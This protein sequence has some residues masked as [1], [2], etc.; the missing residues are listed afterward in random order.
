MWTSIYVQLDEMHDANL[1]ANRSERMFTKTPLRGS[2]SV[3]RNIETKSTTVVKTVFYSPDPAKVPSH[4]SGAAYRIDTNKALSNKPP[5]TKEGHA[6][7]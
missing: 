3:D 4:L 1:I 6:T 5:R 7:V 2:V